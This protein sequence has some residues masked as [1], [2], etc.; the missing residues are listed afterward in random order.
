[1]PRGAAVERMATPGALATSE[2][3][4]GSLPG[5]R[6][7][8]RLVDEGGHRAIMC[9]QFLRVEGLAI[10]WLNTPRVTVDLGFFFEGRKVKHLVSEMN[11]KFSNEK[12]D[13]LELS[14]SRFETLFISLTS[15][16]FRPSKKNPRSTVTR[17][18]S[19][20]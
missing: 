11:K 2:T 14:R 5:R 6:Q 20:T 13:H 1:M 4:R 12:S 18:C 17:G 16:D 19:A 7:L 3:S 15:V 9:R 8:R 10:R